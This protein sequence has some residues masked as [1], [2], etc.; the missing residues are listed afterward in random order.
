MDIA[1]DTATDRARR[2]EDHAGVAIG[3][4]DDE[5][6]VTDFGGVRCGRAL[7]DGVVEDFAGVHLGAV[8]GSA[9]RHAAP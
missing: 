4:V 5:G 2:V 6:W 8:V 7:G 9:P 1:T 3:R